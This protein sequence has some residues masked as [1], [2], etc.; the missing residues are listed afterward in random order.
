MTFNPE[1]L[2]QMAAGF[3]AEF[4]DMVVTC[5]DMRTAGDHAIFV[6]SLEGHHAETKNHAKSGEVEIRD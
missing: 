5:D 2:Q 3:Y 4:P 6:W 1:D